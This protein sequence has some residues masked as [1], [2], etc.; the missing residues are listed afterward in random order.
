MSRRQPPRKR[1]RVTVL[2]FTLC[3]LTAISFILVHP[4]F[5]SILASQAHAVASKSRVEWSVPL[6]TALG[7]YG[8][9]PS[10]P[11][12]W[13]RLSSSRPFQV[14]TLWILV[15]QGG[16]EANVV[17]STVI[18]ALVFTAME[19]SRAIE[20]S[21]LRKLLDQIL[22]SAQTEPSASG[23]FNLF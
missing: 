10:P 20:E 23:V 21:S 16:G 1:V 14:A 13:V 8:G 9:F 19:I 4:L 18:T 11:A 5:S 3:T 6:A 17:W 7:A 2:I 15:Y 22:P 12:W